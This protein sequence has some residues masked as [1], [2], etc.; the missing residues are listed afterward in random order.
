MRALKVLLASVASIATVTSASKK[1]DETGTMVGIGTGGGGGMPAASGGR[2]VSN[3]ML[4][5]ARKPEPLVRADSGLPIGHRHVR[6][7]RRP[8][9]ART[10]QVGLGDLHPLEPEAQRPER[11][12]DVQRHPLRADQARRL[13]LV[14][15]LGAQIEVEAMDR[16]RQV[17][18]DAGV[19]RIQN[20]SRV[21][22]V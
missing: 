4:K 13:R 10:D 11:D 1:S 8:E 21:R 15:E 19:G 5:A 7:D 3:E 17:E 12:R 14:L 16:V 9:R 2:A 22:R 6:R 20:E 18:D